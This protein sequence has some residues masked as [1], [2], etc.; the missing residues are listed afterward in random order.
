MVI[1]KIMEYSTVV[2]DGF[3]NR[4]VILQLFRKYWDLKK[5]NNVINVNQSL[6]VL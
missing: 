3:L 6:T 4:V 1:M 5:W 2:D